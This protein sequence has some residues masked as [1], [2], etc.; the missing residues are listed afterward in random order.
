MLTRR[1]FLKTTALATAGAALSARSFAQIA[2]ANADI[3]V[4]LAGL[5][6]RGRD[7]VAGF[8]KIPGVRV[9]ALCDVDT[10][11]LARALAIARTAAPDR[12]APQTF[13]DFRELLEKAGAHVDAV[14][15][16]TPNHQHALQAIWAMQAGK[17]V[18]L[19]KPISH[20]LWEGWQILAAAKNYNRIVQTGTQSRSSQAIRDAVEW[21][22]AGHLGRITAARAICYKRRFSL[23]KT[24]TPVSPPPTVNYDLWLGP[25]PLAP[26]HRRH[27][28]YDWHWQW[29]T[30]NGE[31][32]NQGNHQIDV[33]RWF[34][35]EPA[36]APRVL[37][38]GGRLGYSDDGK[39]PN[40][41]LALHDYA[42]APL[43][44][45]IRGLPAK[46]N[47]DEPPPDPK[48]DPIRAASAAA[49]TMDR[50]EGLTVGNVI[51]C[52]GGRVVV[53]TFNRARIRVLDRDGKLVREF[54]GAM[55]DHYANFIDAVRSRKAA[56]L[57][58]PIREG[59]V[60]TSLAHCA[61][62]SHQLGRAASPSE[63]HAAA[64]VSPALSEACDRLFAHLE[65]NAVDLAQT[66]LTLGLP[67]TLDPATERFTG[68]CAAAATTK[69][70][71]TYRAPF[72]VPQLA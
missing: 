53:P 48:L 10:D 24:T 21:T 16:A 66:P 11:V 57:R 25:A 34:L 20:T 47:P 72:V 68:D 46:F 5:N 40:T 55:Q 69:I 22:H 44:T 15:I 45:E 58:A 7:L 26:L 18:Y 9:T 70:S 62:I 19:E 51:H 2:G 42:A 49:G 28:H 63:I 65:R 71:Q 50:Y 37:T 60:S 32:A 52:E 67:L 29:A 56:A 3:R 39:T 13:V 4:A 59:F 36:L 43:I 12:A 54:T 33:A 41:L 31:V 27:F 30:G 61:N 38:I 64:Q 35:G 17:D 14:V 1:T 6:I 8:A 23:G